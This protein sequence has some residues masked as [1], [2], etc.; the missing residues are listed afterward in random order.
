MAT[1]CFEGIR[2]IRDLG[3]IK[4]ADGHVIKDKCLYKS[5]TLYTATESDVEKLINDCNVAMVIDLRTEI[6]RKMMPNPCMKGV[7]EIWNP[8][9]MEHIQGLEITDL[10]SVKNRIKR[11][12]FDAKAFMLNMYSKV[13]NNQIIQKQMKQ[14][15]HMISNERGGAILWHCSAG[16]D[17][18]GIMTALVLAA[19]GVSKEEIIKNYVESAE[20]SDDLVDVIVDKMFPL[21]NEALEPFRKQARILFGGDSC[22]IDV[23]FDAIEKDYV[24]VENYLQKALEVRIDN[25]VR[26]KT[27]YLK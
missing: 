26:L 22:Y 16:K 13:V 6:E 2:N 18:T 25:I 8:I 12:E 19:L 10:D 7:S 4:T 3:G 15:F 9:Y 24:T 14:F 20:T 1:I 27:L 23:F 17:R 5:A 21:G 11:N